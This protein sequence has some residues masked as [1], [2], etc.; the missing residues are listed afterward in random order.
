S[1]EARRARD[2]VG[3]PVDEDIYAAQPAEEQL[4][5]LEEE[6]ISQ[7]VEPPVNWSDDHMLHHI[8]H[9]ARNTER[10]ASGKADQAI[11]E[12]AMN[13]AQMHKIKMQ[14]EMQ[15]AMPPPPVAPGGPV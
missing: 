1:I 3:T 2:M 4:I 7:G 15:A 6:Q 5:R 8:R 10:V 11:L 14:E 9:K 12:V 13:H